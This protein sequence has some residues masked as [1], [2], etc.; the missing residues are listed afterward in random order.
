MP[1]KILEAQLIQKIPQRVEFAEM[2][3]VFGG[4]IETEGGVNK[5]FDSVNEVEKTSSLKNQKLEEPEVIYVLLKFSKFSPAA[6]ENEEFL[7]FWP[8]IIFKS[9]STA[10]KC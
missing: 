6:L 3:A 10:L 8:S 1:E 7:F 5:S 2:N 4:S 9:S